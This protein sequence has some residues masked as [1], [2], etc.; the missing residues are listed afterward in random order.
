V[1]LRAV[2]LDLD[3]TLIPEDE[4]LATAYLAVVREIHGG[5]A[6]D[7]HVAALRAGL[8]ARW[9]R[10]APCPDYRARVQVN[11]SDGLIA[12]FPGDDPA[13]AA[14]R[15]YLPRFRAEAFADA[16]G[17]DPAD[18]LLSLWQ[19]TRVETQTAYPHA[20]EVLARLRR[21][22]RLA[23]VTNGP[24]DLQRRKLALTG[25]E[26]HFDVVVASCDIGVGKPDP[27][28]FAAALDRLGVSA[29][30]TVMVGNDRERDVEGASGAGIRS[31]WIQ[32]GSP[33]NGGRA[34]LHH[35]RQVPGLLG[36]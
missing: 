29:S 36:L 12:D 16:P 32:H 25:L 30:Q 11:A 31:L 14:I 33:E 4:P 34:D 23:L 15:D 6:G 9:R 19:R 18:E 35:L 22:V 5:D 10:E 8:R 17:S 26:E 20:A 3:E 24:S 2:L 1:A 13:L 28:I 27:A 7:E 21:R